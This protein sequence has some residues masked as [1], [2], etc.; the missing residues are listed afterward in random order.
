[1][2]RRARS[3]RRM[4]DRWREKFTQAKADAEVREEWLEAVHGSRE[5]LQLLIWSPEARAVVLA[6]DEVPD[7]VT[8]AMLLAACERALGDLA[9]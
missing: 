6:A 8:D 2:S 9:D 7:G 5:D 4:Q 3:K 1:M